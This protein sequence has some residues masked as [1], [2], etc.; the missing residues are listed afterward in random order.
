MFCWGLDHLNF[1]RRPTGEQP[2]VSL[3]GLNL[4]YGV[5]SRQSATGPDL[6][7]VRV[8]FYHQPRY[9]RCLYLW[10]TLRLKVYS[11]FYSSDWNSTIS[12]HVARNS[13]HPNICLFSHLCS[14]IRVSNVFCICWEYRCSTRPTNSRNR[15]A[16]RIFI[17]LS[18]KNTENGVHDVFGSRTNVD[19][20]AQP[21]DWTITLNHI[22]RN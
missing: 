6:Q 8:L 7:H 12:L 4:V 13:L 19:S 2:S 17:A 22:G 20:F 11:R 9:Y 21:N 16:S 3:F 5:P 1:D 18:F 10:R 14:S 15:Q